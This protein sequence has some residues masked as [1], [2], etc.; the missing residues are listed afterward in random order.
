MRSTAAMGQGDWRNRASTVDERLYR[1]C[2]GGRQDPRARFD[3][4]C[5]FVDG[6]I[7]CLG[8]R[9]SALANFR[10]T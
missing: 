5:E 7:H 10:S 3:E 6:F 1:T 9:W 8:G 4:K 2:M